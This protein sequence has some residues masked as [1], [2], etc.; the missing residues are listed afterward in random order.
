[1][2]EI[3][4]GLEWVCTEYHPDLIMVVGDVNS[5]FAAALTANKLV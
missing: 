1:M 2:A 3:M 4:I 5:T